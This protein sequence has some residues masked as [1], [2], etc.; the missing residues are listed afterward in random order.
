MGF[1]GIGDVLQAELEF[2]GAVVIFVHF[3]IIGGVYYLLW[4]VLWSLVYVGEVLCYGTLGSTLVVYDL[5]LTTF[6]SLH[7]SGDYWMTSLDS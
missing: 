6:V 5:Y 3:Y 1:W 7:H 2:I 4:Y